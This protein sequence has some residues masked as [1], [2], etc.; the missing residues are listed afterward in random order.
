LGRSNAGKII[1][2]KRA[3][4]VKKSLFEKKQNFLKQALVVL[5]FVLSGG[6]K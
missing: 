4:E 5:R 6:V 1:L 2:G 3:Y